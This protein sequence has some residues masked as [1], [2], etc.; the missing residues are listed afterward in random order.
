MRGISQRLLLLLLLDG[1]MRESYNTCLT[2]ESS[3]YPT[4]LLYRPSGQ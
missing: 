3:N 2:A 1:E 4:S